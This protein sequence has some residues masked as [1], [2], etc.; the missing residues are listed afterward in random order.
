MVQNVK[1]VS[2]KQKSD[3]IKQKYAKGIAYVKKKQ[4]LC[5]GFMREQQK[6]FII[7]CCEATFFYLC[8][9]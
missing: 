4:Y 8:Y 5:I 2:K 6:V 9:Y 1:F 7:S 3:I